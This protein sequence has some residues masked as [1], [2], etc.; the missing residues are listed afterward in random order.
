MDIESVA[1]ENFLAIDRAI[2]NLK[3][4]GLVAIEG[5]N[6][7]DP[8]ASSNGSAKSSIVDAICWCLYGTTARGATGDEVVNDTA[9]KDCVVIVSMK[10]GSTRWVV[11]RARKHSLTKNR[12]QLWVDDGSGL[13][14]ITLGIEKETQALVT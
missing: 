12:L 14:E 8:S 10:E 11:Q 7:D 2:I 6:K 3:N 9:G 13:K 4:R 1:I 5:V